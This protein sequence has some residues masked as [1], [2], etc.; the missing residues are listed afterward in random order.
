MEKEDTKNSEDKYLPGEDGDER[1]FVGAVKTHDD[2]HGC[3]HLLSYG[4]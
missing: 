1:T 2:A 4:S 3:D